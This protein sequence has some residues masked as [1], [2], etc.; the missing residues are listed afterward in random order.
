MGRDD[1]GIVNS[2]QRWHT[3]PRGLAFVLHGTGAGRAVLLLRGAA[4]RRI[5]PN[6]LN[7]VGGHVERDEDVRKSIEREIGE[8]TG[9]AVSDLRLRGIV[10]IDSGAAA[11]IMMFVWTAESATRTVRPSS[12]GGLEWHPLS[13]LPTTDL[14][15]DLAE[16]LPR[17]VLRPATA[18]PFFARYSYD[19][20]DRL[21]IA[22]SDPLADAGNS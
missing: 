16:L 19:A 2:R 18:P 10:H 14:V 3:I 15:D 11:G 20:A 6:R 9:L 17:S 22:W 21:H 1:Q 7:G 5:W 8:E 4:T 13:Q 12:E